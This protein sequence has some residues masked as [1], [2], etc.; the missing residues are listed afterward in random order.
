MQNDLTGIYRAIVTNTADPQNKKRIR[1]KVPQVAGSAE[2]DWVE[3]VNPVLP[4]PVVGTILWVMFNGGYINKPVYLP[5]TETPNPVEPTVTWNLA[6]LQTG[7]T[8]NGNAS[9]NVEWAEYTVQGQTWLEFRGAATVA[10]TGTFPNFLIPNG[11]VVFQLPLGNRPSVRR[12]TPISQNTYVNTTAQTANHSI[13]VDI[14]NNGNVVLLGSAFI[15]TTF[16]S[17]HGIRFTK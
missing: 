15:Q 14:N 11:G 3:P 4:L 7:F 13:K 9:G 6:P 12:T 16:V 8:H 10:S 2:L 17:F 1:V 5:A